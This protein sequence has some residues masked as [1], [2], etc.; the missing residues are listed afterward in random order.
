MRN[1]SR[2]A[3]STV[4]RLLEEY[5][6]R[7]TPQIREKLVEL[8]L[9]IA[10]IIARRLSGRGVDY[11]D[12]Y[13]V[14][15]L[16]LFKAVDRYD[17]SRG[18]KFASFVTPTMVGE[19]KNYFR[20]KSR[21]IRLP[22]RGVALMREIDQAKERLAQQL[23]RMPR[24]DELAEALGLPEADILEALETGGAASVVS[25]DAAPDGDE[26]TASLDSFL[27]MEDAGYSR[28][29]RSDAIE[30]AMAALNARQ[31]Q[32]IHMRYFESK[33]QREIAMAMNVSQ[34]TIS[35]EERRALEIM[36]QQV[37]PAADL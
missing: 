18:I 27:G 5:T 15:A 16:A 32:I 8:H 20:D 6:L 14:A 34:M 10:E 23:D 29:E 12:L 37:Q 17:P 30:R 22:R 24:S 13:Q 35:R 36:R 7:P 2:A 3:P 28:F 25:L 4:E 31:R 21:T 26:D 33:S 9:Y 19:V 11:D 1:A